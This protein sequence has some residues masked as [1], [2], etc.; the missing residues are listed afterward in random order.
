METINLEGNASSFDFYL[1]SSWQ[2][3]N[4][5]K[6]IVLYVTEKLISPNCG[7]Q[8]IVISRVYLLMVGFLTSSLIELIYNW[9]CFGWWFGWFLGYQNGNI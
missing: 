4:F 9:H 3:I 2:P 1:C 7:N 6:Y 8:L 5:L